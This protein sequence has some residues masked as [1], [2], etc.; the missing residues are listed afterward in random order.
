VLVSVAVAIVA[1][2]GL[3]YYIVTRPID[4]IAVLPFIS[5]GSDPVTQQLADDIGERIISDL[6]KLPGL[7][8]KSFSAVQH[9]KGQTI[10][11]QA[12]GRELN[13]DAV[14]MG[15]VSKRGDNAYTI[16]AEL[17]STKDGSVVVNPILEVNFSDVLLVPDKIV[18]AVSDSE[19]IG[20]KMSV[21][22]KKKKDAETLIVKGRN[23]WNK[24]TTDGINDAIGNFNEALALD[25]KSALA[26]AGLA[27]CYNML[28]TYGAKPPKEV[29]PKAHDAAIKALAINDGLA[30]AHAALAYT[31]FRGDWNL[32]E[33]E[34]EF[35]RA[36]SLREDYASTHQ[37]YANLLAAQGRFDEAIQETKRAQEIDKTSL[38]IQAHLGN[39]N[40]LAQRF[41]QA[42]AECQ[43]ALALDPGFFAARRYLGLSYAQKGMYREALAEFEKAV[44]GSN[45]SPQVKAEYAG[46]LALSGDTAR[47]QTELNS[48]IE[49][50]KQRYVSAYHIA[51]V[52]AALKDKEHTFEWLEKAFQERADYLAF[53]NVEPRFDDFHSDPRFADL[54]RRMKAG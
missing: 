43:K 28:S 54:L 12:A 26:Y 10:D 42:I 27:D 32:P 9:Y 49:M 39:M 31:T 34:R 25:P 35:K 38:I 11:P 22:E 15:R 47:A 20:L 2:A 41:D 29:I 3:R 52:Y 18:A 46:V 17:I 53:V 36:I 1:I 24:R 37:W 45:N 14:M 16:R 7:T 19:K 5:T 40:Y 6:S 44:A 30:E 13:V 4:S 51:L 21:D 8:V 23:A 33:A 50:S 48:L